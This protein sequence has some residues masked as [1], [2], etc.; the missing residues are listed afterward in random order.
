MCVNKTYNLVLRSINKNSGTN[1][2]AS[3]V[4][5]W[6][7]LLSPEFKEF[8]VKI[9][10]LTECIQYDPI[11]DPSALEV[12][13]FM[14]KASIQDTNNIDSLVHHCTVN[15]L[16]NNSSSTT[17]AN[18]SSLNKDTIYSIQRPT[19]NIINI[20]IYNNEAMLASSTYSTTYTSYYEGEIN[21]V[22][23]LEFTPIK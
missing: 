11:Y 20:K 23:L 9:T 10:M 7:R 2:N 19:D 15:N 5:N 8:N 16:L 13:F 1:S 3:F 22:V 21:Y 4:I 6:E 17:Y 12:R 14:G 18:Y